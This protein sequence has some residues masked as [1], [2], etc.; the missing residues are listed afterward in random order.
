MLAWISPY[1]VLFEEPPDYTQIKPFGCLGYVTNSVLHKGKF[2]TRSIKSIF[3]GFDTNHKGFLIYD[4]ENAKVFISRDVKLVN[5]TFPYNSPN[6][7]SSEPTVSLPAVPTTHSDES[8]LA[9][10]D[11]PSPEFHSNPPE[12]IILADDDETPSSITKPANDAL[13][14]LRKSTRV[15]KLPVWMK[16]CV[17]SVNLAKP[18]S[19]SCSITPPT[20]PY[21]ISHALSKTYTTYLFNLTMAKEPSSYKEACLY[22]EWI[23]AMNAE[24][25]ALI[26]NKT[27][28]LT[29][30]PPNKK[31][32]G[33]KWIYKVKLKADGTI[34]RCKAR[35][36]AKGFSQEYRVDYQEVFSPL[37]N[38]VTMR[39][40]IAMA[41]ASL[42]IFI[43][44]TLIMLS[45]MVFYMMKLI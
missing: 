15:R 41:T 16:D 9:N 45:Y 44:L 38:L 20:F 35:L 5:D 13:P 43:N 1:E 28:K 14:L 11:F 7:I 22:P 8:H 25:H 31:P 18:I 3:L 37:A 21:D 26:D 40:F 10:D 27:W 29:E 4:L 17:G 33:C 6:K 32:I 34:E 23:E 19:L 12:N 24:L 2:D 30:L 39:V 42:G 36:V